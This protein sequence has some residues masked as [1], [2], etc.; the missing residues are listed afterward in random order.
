MKYTQRLN[1]F[2]PTRTWTLTPKALQWHDDKGASGEIELSKVKEVR[3]RFE[4]SRAETRRFAMHINAGT[5]TTI[6]NINY[7]GVMD[8]EARSDEFRNFVIAFH[9]ALASTNPSVIYHQGSTTGA[10]IGNVLLSLFVFGI[11]I[12][13]FFFFLFAGVVWVA[14]VKLVIILALIPTL[15]R[16]LK[17]NRPGTYR[18]DDIP[19]ELLP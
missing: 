5:T 12:F 2:T 6:T 18:P 7:R 13:A 19:A 11:I 16:F 9:K 1:Q 8:F 15:I 10:Y 17:R 14:L 4:P 3:L